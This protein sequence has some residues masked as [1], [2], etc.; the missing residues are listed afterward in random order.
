MGDGARLSAT[1]TFTMV[2]ALRAFGGNV[3]PPLAANAL[4]DNHAPIHMYT[5]SCQLV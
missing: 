4:D 1:Y 5:Y 3:T 2:V